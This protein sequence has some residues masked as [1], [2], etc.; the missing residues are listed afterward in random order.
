MNQTAQRYRTYLETLTFEDIDRLSEFAADDI[1]FKDPFNEVRGIE[2]MERVLR[3]M[4]RL[5]SG[6][7]FSIRHIAVDGEY[8][9]MEWRFEGKLHWFDVDFEGTS[10]VRFGS[11][12]KVLSHTDYWDAGRAFYEKL[13]IIGIVFGFLRR[14]V[15]IN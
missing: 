7:R 8:C 9:M 6:I 13:P 14:A 12:G 15:A 1:R 2:A 10:V 11:D 3:H 5:I 4:F